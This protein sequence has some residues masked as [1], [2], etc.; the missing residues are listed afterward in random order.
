MEHAKGKCQMPQKLTKTAII[1]DFDGTLAR[2][3][4]QETSFIPNIGMEK[5]EFWE[6]VGEKKRE[7]DADQ[8]LVYMHLM[9]K[10]AQANKIKVTREMLKEH[11]RSADLFD[12]LAH[13]KWFNRI[14]DIA[15]KDGLELEHYILS[16]GIHEMILGCQIANEFK[17][18][19]ASR[20]IYDDEGVAL[21]P[22]V[23]INY[24]TKTQYLFRINKG[25]DNNWDN[26]VINSYMADKDRPIPFSRMIFVGDGDTDIPSMKMLTYQGGHSIAVYDPSRDHRSISK[27]HRLISEDRVNF[28]APA[29]YSEDSQFEII[30]K[31]ILGRIGLAC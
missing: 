26:S 17:Q 27:I 14:N 5:E 16:S 31:G 3:N 22:A 18:I 2:G 6:L 19:F 1:Y 9:L 13:A 20:Y 15:A 30:I 21:W 24:T 12:G 7:E 25:I 29:D 11:G 8:I 23:A 28:V 4:L 10:Y